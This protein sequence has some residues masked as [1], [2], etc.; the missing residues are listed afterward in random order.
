[1][2]HSRASPYELEGRIGMAPTVYLVTGGNRGIG[3]AIVTALAPRPDVVVFAGA[4][5]PTRSTDLHALANAHSGRV[6]V[7]KIV[8]ADKENNKAAIEEIKRVAGRLDVVIANAGIGDSYET[9][10]EVPTEQM[11]RHFEINTNGPLVLFQVTY[12]LLRESQMPKFVTI[13]SALGSIALAGQMALN[14]YAYGASKAAVNWVMRKLHH[15][16]PDMVI[17]PISPGRVLTDMAQAASRDDTQ[18]QRAMRDAFPAITP[19]ESAGGI[20]EQ[21]N[22]ATRETHGGQFVDVT[23]LGK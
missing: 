17:F 3:L 4:R 1:M 5:D 20:L 21:I 10:L 14:V 7:I 11:V 6:H 16:F 12:P 9:A 2:P 22:V 23:G 15:D 19:E 13:S 8:S 18:E